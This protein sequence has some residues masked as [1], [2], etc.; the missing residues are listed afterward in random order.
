M[1]EIARYTL[2]TCVGLVA[3]TY[4]G[5][6]LLLALLAL[7]PR[8]RT[9]WPRQ[10]LPTISIT[11]PVHN[12][13][14]QVRPLLESLL[15][16]EYPSELR[17]ILVVSDASSDATDDIVRTFADRGVE[18]LRM[19]R[20]VGKTAAENAA[21][22]HLRGEIIV[23]TDASVRIERWA[24]RHLVRRFDD[25]R[26]GLA[27]AR[28]VSVA[29]GG[30]R[31]NAGESGYVGYEMR[32]RALETRVGGIVGASG[33]LYAIRRALHMQP[34]PDGLSRDFASALIAREHGF[35]A[36]SVNAAKCYVPRAPSLQREYERKVRTFARGMR[37]LAHKRHLLN[38]LRYGRFAW[39]LASHKLARWL[40]PWALVGGVASAFVLATAYAWAAAMAAAAVVMGG[41]A[42]VGI[43]RPGDRRMP[44]VVSLP[45]FLVLGNLA[46]LAAAVRA[47]RGTSTAVWEPTR[48]DGV[49]AP[50][51]TYPASSS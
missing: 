49:P 32:V 13:A 16:L 34:L 6:P 5:Y 33:C 2:L 10:P 42:V 24:L 37:T 35:R 11:V 40:V 26:V 28:D 46:V 17:Q 1:I 3:W 18:L 27:S 7:V 47:L 22:P 9:A 43:N 20:R 15:A 25:P 41:L 14:A 45:T 30:E 51:R 4:V 39:M 48:R 29:P 44:R 23:N 12:E 31:A 38:P 50:A 8:R 19:E 36:V 21:R